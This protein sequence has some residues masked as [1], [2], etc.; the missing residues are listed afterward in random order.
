[1][2]SY[3]S[4]KRVTTATSMPEAEGVI[5]SVAMPNMDSTLKMVNYASP[6]KQKNSTSSPSRP[7]APPVLKWTYELIGFTIDGDQVLLTLNYW[8]AKTMAK[9]I[10]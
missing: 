7:V 3:N 6:K 4:P 10:E 5:L 2:A 9:F 1:M 8:W